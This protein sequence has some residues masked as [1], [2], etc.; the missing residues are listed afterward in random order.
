MGDIREA[1]ANMSRGVPKI[2]LCE[3]CYL[4]IVAYNGT[5]VWRWVYNFLTGERLE[6]TRHSVCPTLVGATH[7]GP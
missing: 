6:F 3:A 1:F 4:P 2:M 7:E 5:I